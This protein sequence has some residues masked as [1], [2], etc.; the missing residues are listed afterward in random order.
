MGERK[1]GKGPTVLTHG[2]A[3]PGCSTKMTVALWCGGCTG[4]RPLCSGRGQCSGAWQAHERWRSPASFSEAQHIRGKMR[5]GGVVG[6]KAREGEV[7][8]W[9]EVYALARDHGGGPR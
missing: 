3:R 1:G 4:R 9:G 7:Y 6:N 5:K 8:A 2:G